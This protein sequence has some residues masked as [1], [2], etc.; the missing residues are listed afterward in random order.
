MKKKTSRRK[1]PEIEYALQNI[2]RMD[3]KLTHGWW[4]RLY[5]VVDGAKKCWSKYFADGIFGGSEQSLFQAKK[6]RGLML[7][8]IP[9]RHRNGGPGI[10]KQPGYSY[11]RFA[12]LTHSPKNSKQVAKT[13]PA[14]TGWIRLEEGGLYKRA[15]IDR[16]GNAGAKRRIEAWIREEK[17]AL[18]ERLSAAKPRAKQRRAA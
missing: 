4:V 9:P 2:T 11:V 16:W 12:I 3:Y 15:S 7:K 18:W 8:T 17:E 5:R 13:Y 6:W 1:P 10:L 14:W